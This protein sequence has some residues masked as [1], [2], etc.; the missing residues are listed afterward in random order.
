VE[1]TESNV[2]TK[3]KISGKEYYANSPVLLVEVISRSTRKTDEQI[4]RLEYINI[5]SLEEFVLIEQDYVD[6]AVFRKSQSWQPTHYFLGDTVK[7]ESIGLT[8]AVET[9]Y[10]RVENQDM[11][12]FLQAQ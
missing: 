10:K 5:S 4:K 2:Q 9:I 3:S 1:L 12:D 11:T 7:F 8:L 6:V